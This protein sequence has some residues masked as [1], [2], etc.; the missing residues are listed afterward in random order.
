LVQPRAI[1]AAAMRAART[2]GVAR[3]ID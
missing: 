1:E 2:I 3:G